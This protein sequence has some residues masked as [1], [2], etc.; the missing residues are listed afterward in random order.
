MS[1]EVRRSGGCALRC[2]AG[3]ELR[4]VST[5]NV[6]S[7]Q[8]EAEHRKQSSVKSL[9]LHDSSA[10]ADMRATPCVGSD[11]KIRVALR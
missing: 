7:G 3:S 5:W 1:A 2:S 10:L 11:G 8:W 6:S 4:C 9:L